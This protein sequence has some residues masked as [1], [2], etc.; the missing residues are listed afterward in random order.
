[1]YILVDEKQI[2]GRGGMYSTTPDG[3][4]I[5]PMNDLKVFDTLYG[6]DII[7]SKRILTNL[8]KQMKEEA[9]KP[10]PDPSTEEIDPTFGVTQETIDEAQKAEPE[11]ID[12][13]TVEQPDN[14]K[15]AQE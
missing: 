4:Y 14:K 10:K 13:E 5:V 6:V 3:R 8:I 9:L 12:A 15:G 1:M 2:N 11:L 7:P